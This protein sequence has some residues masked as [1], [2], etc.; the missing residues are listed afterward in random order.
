ML[1]V[2]DGTLTVNLFRRILADFYQEWL[3]YCQ[4]V[5][6]TKMSLFRTGLEFTFGQ[7]VANFSQGSAGIL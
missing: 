3:W 2:G 6:W 7:T 1:F 4:K 5:H